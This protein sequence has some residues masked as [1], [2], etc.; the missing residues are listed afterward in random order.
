MP[1]CVEGWLCCCRW[2]WFNLAAAGS[3]DVAAFAKLFGVVFF[4]FFCRGIFFFGCAGSEW[5][6]MFSPDSLKI[7]P[8]LNKGLVFVLGSGWRLCLWLYLNKDLS[9][10]G[11]LKKSLVWSCFGAGFSSFLLPK[12][13]EI[14]R[15]CFL[16]SVKTSGRAREVKRWFFSFL[17]GSGASRG[18]A[19]RLWVFFFGFFSLRK[20]LTAAWELILNWLFFLG[21]E[22]KLP[23]ELWASE[24]LR[25]WWAGGWWWGGGRS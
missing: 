15:L 3:A 7:S 6:H 13:L 12:T 18:A 10:Y 9:L 21:G 4:C 14:R 24:D 8:W 5:A 19:C 16:G 2:R 11:R 1:A 23:S 25:Q 22:A 20:C 17:F